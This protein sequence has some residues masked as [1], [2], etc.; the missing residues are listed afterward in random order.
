MERFE[1]ESHPYAL[2]RAALEPLL[3]GDLPGQA[4]LAHGSSPAAFAAFLFQQH[5]Q[6][7]WLDLIERHGSPADY[8]LLARDLTEGAKTW[9]IR[10]LPQQRIMSLAHQALSAEGIAYFFAKGAHLRHVLYAEPVLRSATDV[11]VF[12]QQADREKA[13]NALVCCSF[14]AQPLADTISHELKLTRHHGDID[15]HW[16]IFRPGRACPVLMDWLFDHREKFGKFWGLNA[17]ASLLVM[18]VHPAITKYLLS[19]ASMLIHQVDQA[20]LIAS[21]KVDW[22]ELESALRCSGVKTAAW[23]SLYVL[24][25]LGGVEAPDGFEERIRPGGLQA[26]YLRQWIDRAWITKWFD[27]R[28]LVAGLFSLTLQDNAADALR[29]LRMLRSARRDAAKLIKELQYRG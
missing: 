4:A 12:V 15:L 25:K 16:D 1:W 14:T 11:D 18:L 27:R 26:W 29:A 23:S 28:W 24:R 7:L 5:L 22:D 3:S 13:I 6:T 9:A 19:P 8:A 10:E 20:R 2:H 21:E 17:T